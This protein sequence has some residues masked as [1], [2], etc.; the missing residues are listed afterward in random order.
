MHSDDQLG[1]TSS[2]NSLSRHWHL[3]KR[4]PIALILTLLIQSA[5]IAWWMASTTEKVSVLEKRLDALS[6]QED[7]LTRVEVNIEYIKM[8]LTEIKQALK[9]TSLQDH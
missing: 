6:P 4:V 1:Y 5:G 3:D 8:S 2:D 9:T 7:R